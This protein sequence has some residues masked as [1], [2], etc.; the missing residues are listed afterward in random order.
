MVADDSSIEIESLTATVSTNAVDKVEAIIYVNNG[1]L[2]IDSFT[3]PA[4][5]T[6]LAIGPNAKASQISFTD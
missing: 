4:T 2:T 3:S 5:V 1:R 6:G